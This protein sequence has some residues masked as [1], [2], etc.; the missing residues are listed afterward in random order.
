MSNVGDK[1]TVPFNSHNTPVHQMAGWFTVSRVDAFGNVQE[2]TLGAPGTYAYDTWLPKNPIHPTGGSAT[3]LL[4][5]KWSFTT[6]EA[7]NFKRFYE[8]RPI[9]T[10]G[11]TATGAPVHNFPN[12]VTWMGPLNID[13]PDASIGG[14]NVDQ[15]QCEVEHFNALASMI[16][17]I[18]NNATKFNRTVAGN[19][20]DLQLSWNS[21][22]SR[23]SGFPG[24]APAA[25]PSAGCWPR[26]AYYCWS[27]D[28]TTAQHALAS[29]FQSLGL[30]VY[31][32]ADLPGGLGAAKLNRY[33]VIGQTG[34]VS[35][36]DG[37]AG[38]YLPGYDLT[39]Q[40]A[41]SQY[42]WISIEDAKNYLASISVPLV[43]YGVYT[44]VD[45]QFLQATFNLT[46]TKEPL[47]TYPY[48]VSALDKPN[49]AAEPDLG[50]Y[51]VL[52]ACLIPD[53]AGAYL[54]SGLSGD[55]G[56]VLSSD[57]AHKT[58][59]NADS[60]WAFGVQQW[61]LSVP[62][63][64][65]GPPAGIYGGTYFRWRWQFWVDWG[66]ARGGL[67]FGVSTG[68][69][70]MTDVILVR[71]YGVGNK[72]VIQQPTNYA[73]LDEA[74]WRSHIDVIAGKY[75]DPVVTEYFYDDAGLTQPDQKDIPGGV[76]GVRNA[77]VIPFIAHNDQDN[78]AAATQT[79]AGNAGD[80]VIGASFPNAQVVVVDIDG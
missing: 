68:G 16:N 23:W 69:A 13:S 4:T 66:I 71:C 38:D 70:G 73:I 35:Y 5:V 64:N 55:S 53:A 59:E 11:V 22:A 12:N 72:L 40:A 17:A 78:Q 25:L 74:W 49:D 9:T 47:D 44:P 60:G 46:Y 15:M 8:S 10:D 50:S 32:N 14:N 58:L 42:R 75:N 54:T 21:S 18:P 37:A 56:I 7:P 29:Y 24:Y 79:M 27:D 51:P 19:F 39:F 30:T 34:A 62:D 43:I 20:P 41:V 31:T 28:G 6:S 36:Q 67:N 76:S 57:P 1:L 52:A 48:I 45:F 26:N 77:G 63:P 65:S 61:T 3:I 80:V 33:A 2:V